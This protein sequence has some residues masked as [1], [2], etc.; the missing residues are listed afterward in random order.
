MYCKES[1]LRI[2]YIF[3]HLFYHFF[4]KNHQYEDDYLEVIVDVRMTVTPDSSYYYESREQV[5][6]AVGRAVAN[7]NMK[8]AVS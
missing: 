6:L 5:L 8:F 2:I 4:Q 7:Q 3:S 1:I